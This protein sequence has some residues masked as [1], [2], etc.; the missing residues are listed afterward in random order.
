MQENVRG[1]GYFYYLDLGDGN[2]GIHICLY[3]PTY[4]HLLFAVFAK[5]FYLKFK[6]F[7]VCVF[8]TV[9]S[10]HPGR[11]LRVSF[12]YL[13]WYY[14]FSMVCFQEQLC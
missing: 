9:S 12:S 13:C 6:I 1:N 11:V 7:P 4:I 3:S 14:G 2:V 8:I 5:E 10:W